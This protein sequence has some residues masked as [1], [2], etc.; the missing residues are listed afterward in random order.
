MEPDY[1]QLELDLR[2]WLT[3]QELAIADAPTRP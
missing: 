3:A 2:L 1:D